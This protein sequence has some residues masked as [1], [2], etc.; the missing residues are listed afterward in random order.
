MPDPKVTEICKTE[1]EIKLD[2][3]WMSTTITQL[4]EMKSEKVYK[5][6]DRYRK[7]KV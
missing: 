7:R 1:L 3:K 2:V 6:K 4:P 5:V